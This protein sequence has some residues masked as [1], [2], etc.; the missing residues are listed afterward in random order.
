MTAPAKGRRLLDALRRSGRAALIA[1]VA[2]TAVYTNP[3]SSGPALLIERLGAGLFW[4]IIAFAVVLAFRLE[5][6]V[7]RSA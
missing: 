4:A 5:R 6:P 7:R 2:G 1:L 3:N